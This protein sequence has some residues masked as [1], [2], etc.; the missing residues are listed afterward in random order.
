[1]SHGV[2]R[3]G[4]KD[5]KSDNRESFIN[6]LIKKNK[7]IKFDIYGMNKVQPIWGDNFINKI[8]NCSMGL[9]LSRGEPIKY[10]SSD[11]ISQLVGNGLLTFIDDKT[12][13]RD[14]FSDNEMIFYKNLDDLSNKINKFKKDIKKRKLIAKNGKNSYFKYFNSTIVSDYI[15]T[16]TFGLKTKNIFLWDKS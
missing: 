14:F 3:G 1:M 15:I 9:N 6:K 12:F 5:G 7:N 11:R 4:L 13:Y 16:K 8:S 2:H 10:Y